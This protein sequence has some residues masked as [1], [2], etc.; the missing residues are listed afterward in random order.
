MNSFKLELPTKIYF[1]EQEFLRIKTILNNYLN[2]KALIVTGKGSIKKLKYLEK[3]TEI[4]DTL[5]I[6][7]AIFEGIEPN[8]KHS[9][10]NTASK[11]A[12]E[13]KIDYIIAFGGG[14]VMDASKGIAISTITGE[15]IWKYCNIKNTKKLIVRDA[16]PLICIPTLAATG[17]EVNSGAVIS[18]IETK[19]KA[20]IHSS[21]I[22]PK[23]AIIDPEFLKTVPLNYTIDGGIDII[24]HSLETFISTD[25]EIYPQDY[26]SYSI[27]K[28]VKTALDNILAKKK[29]ESAEAKTLAW[30]SSITMSGFLSGR[31]APWPIHEIE[32]GISAVYDISHGLGL[33][34]ILCNLL[35]FNIESSSSNYA[36]KINKFIG[37]FLH[38]NTYFYKDVN[39]A[40]NDFKSYILSLLKNRDYSFMYNI[41]KKLVAESILSTY[42]SKNYIANLKNL[43]FEDILKILSLNK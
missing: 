2:K 34:F 33:V 29:I 7:Y 35:E 14:S 5:K 26:F 6:K 25:I 39:N 27:S 16:L 38:D 11:F 43:Y 4:L 19:Q 12:R 30:C 22:Y 31:N 9:T 36:N 1:G 13:E 41:D 42:G 8:P 18:N 15:D 17:S 32:H 10:I 28:S 24:V 40:V 37:F 21:K 23:Y 3:L 20:V